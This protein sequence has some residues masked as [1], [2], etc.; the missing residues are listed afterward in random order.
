MTSPYIV[1]QP[2]NFL[3]FTGG[4][5]YLLVSLKKSP[6]N[7]NGFIEDTIFINDS[8]PFELTFLYIDTNSLFLINTSQPLSIRGLVAVEVIF[9]PLCVEIVQSPLWSLSQRK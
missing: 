9:P 5:P 2:S 7:P 1:K 3:S 6:L 4:N 8:S